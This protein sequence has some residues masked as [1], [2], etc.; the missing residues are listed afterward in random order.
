MTITDKDIGGCIEISG[1]D[2]ETIK[3]KFF[4]LF[5]HKSI[6]CGYSL[7]APR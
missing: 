6:G 3:I 5:L 2:E 7:E 1:T 4:F